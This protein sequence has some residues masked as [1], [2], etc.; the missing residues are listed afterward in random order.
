MN[1][2]KLRKKNNLK[3]IFVIAGAA[4]LVII[5]AGIAFLQFNPAYAM[6]PLAKSAIQDELAKQAQIT[7]DL[8]A[9]YQAGTYTFDSPLVVQDPYQ[10]APLTALAI[11][12]TP[13][14]SQISIHVPGK[15]PQAA[16]DFTFP[17]Y[18]KHHEIP[19][20]GLYA[21]TLNHVSMTMQAQNG[22]KSET[23]IDLQTE[24]LPVQLPTFD[25]TKVDVQKYAPG[26]NFAGLATHLVIFDLQGEIRWY[27]PQISYQVVTKLANGRFLRTFSDGLEGN[28]MMEQ[29]LLGK[30]YGVY[31]VADGVHH[32]V[33]ELPNGNF[34]VTSSDMRST[35]TK[36]F[37][38]EVSR[39]TGHIVRS[40]DL[41]NVLDPGRPHQ[42][43]Q[44]AANDWLHL[45]SVVYD[46]T[47]QSIIISSKGQSAVVKLS[48]PSMKI[49]WILGPHD[50][51]SA[52]Y[53]PYLLTP[54]GNGFEWEWSQHHATLYAPQEPGS[55]YVD[56]L[57]FDNGNYRSFTDPNAF[58]PS[59]W[60]SRVVLYQIDEANKTV[61]TLWEYGRELGSAAFSAARG[62][63]Y[64]LGN[65]DILGT[66]GDI[67]RTPEGVASDHDSD[68]NSAQTRIIE[69]NQDSGEVV[70]DCS[71]MAETYRT[72]RDSMYDG[73]S[74][75]SPYLVNKVNNTSPVDLADR[76]VLGV[77][78][79]KRV[80]VA[81]SIEVLRTIYHWVKARV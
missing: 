55:P 38:I 16:L 29:D 24:P 19:I 37:L 52:K 66:W 74:E 26:F 51:W 32:D 39:K 47:D 7:K 35:S 25:I 34:L 57:L 12:D 2:K 72:M 77:R 49:K 33:Y 27:S 79:F 1:L 10:L 3:K 28:V 64:H 61:K 41:R 58:L 69:V 78:D 13:E 21:D 63:A 75:N 70:F 59:E 81:P 60:Y 45:N 4:A 5:L 76:W 42:I 53:Q 30:V 54:E 23:T 14:D 8:K 9:T 11:F 68:V 50:N 48:Y 6:N 20:Y 36:D 43:L 40:F 31:Y 80:V 17:G 46:S 56:I 62:S 18:Q 22:A 44:L 65:G 67:Y 73:Y 15:I 71:V